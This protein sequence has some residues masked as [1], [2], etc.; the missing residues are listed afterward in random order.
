[1]GCSSLQGTGDKGY[2][3]GSG[4]VV[5]VEPGQR[6][7]PISLTGRDLEGDPL[8]TSEFRGTPVVAVVW[9]SWCAPCRAEAPDVVAA[10]EEVGDRAQ[11]VGINIR[12]GSPEQARS[13]VRTFDVPYPSFYSPDGEAMLA[14]SGTLTPNSIPSFVVLDADGRVAA[15]IIGEL[16][17]RTTLVEVVEDV[18][19]EQPDGQRDGQRDG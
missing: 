1:M 15:T 17:S 12:D 6:D 19:A 3:S 11:F 4:E 16:P 5:Q 10:A 9:G 8:S 18:V 7:E 2:V 13:F 14:F